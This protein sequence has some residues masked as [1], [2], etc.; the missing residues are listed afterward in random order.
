M[1]KANYHTHTVFCDGKN[2]PEEI[3]EEAAR[4]GLEELG[5]SGH[6]YTFFDE[7]YCMSKQGTK[8]YCESIL[9]L[10]EKYKGKIKIL[11][12]VEQD[13][14]SNEPTEGYDFVIGSVHYV[15]KDGAYIPLDESPKVLTGAVKKHYNGDFYAF[16]EDYYALVSDI[17]NKTKCDIIGH[18][19]LI[20]KFNEGNALFDASDERYK[21]A[22]KAAAEVLLKTPAVFE[23]NTGAMS[24]GYRGEPYPAKEI[25]DMLKSGGAK[26]LY[27]SDCHEAANLL[28]GFEECGKIIF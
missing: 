22:A 1:I 16:A 24:R 17:Y 9:K 4:L 3:A 15:K 10:K 25:L 11:L 21:S 8:E 28:F 18:F 13:Y 26:L 14:F 2:T 5:F 6:S 23:V 7:S 19:D 12:G 27:S 20:T